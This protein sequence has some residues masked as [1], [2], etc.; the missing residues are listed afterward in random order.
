MEVKQ[1]VA[2][3]E[4]LRVGEML[5]RAARVRAGHRS[6]RPRDAAPAHALI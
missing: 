1:Q 2:R 6:P 3:T 4:E 5:V